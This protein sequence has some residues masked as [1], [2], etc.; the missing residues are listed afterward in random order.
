MRKFWWELIFALACL[1]MA[2]IALRAEGITPVDGEWWVIVA[3]FPA[4]NS[5]FDYFI[6]DYKKWRKRP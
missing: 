2:L 4:F 1:T 5:L 6:E 3:G